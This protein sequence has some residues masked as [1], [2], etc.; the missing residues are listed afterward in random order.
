MYV[1]GSII[2]Y[3]YGWRQRLPDTPSFVLQVRSLRTVHCSCFEGPATWKQANK[4]EFR[5]DEPTR[6]YFSSAV[7]GNGYKARLAVHC[8]D[9]QY[10]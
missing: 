9:F 5:F 2:A 8:V 6:T 3:G 10:H 4:R 1:V 7:C